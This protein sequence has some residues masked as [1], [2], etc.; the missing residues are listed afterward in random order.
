[1]AAGACLSPTSY[2]R[3]WS[4]RSTTSPPAPVSGWWLLHRQRH[5]ST[6]KP[7]GGRT[8]YRR[9]LPP[10]V[11]FPDDHCPAEH[12]QEMMGLPRR[13][14]PG[15]MAEYPH[16]VSPAPPGVTEAYEHSCL[17]LFVLHSAI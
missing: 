9:T 15:L 17:P 4:A 8:R 12:T 1:H 2:T 16:S 10:R 3:C 11:R 14:R 7:S 6:T 13:G 5:N